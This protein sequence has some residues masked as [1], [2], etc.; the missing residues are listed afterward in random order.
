M[1]RIILPST[2]LWTR[3]RTLGWGVIWN[4]KNNS[5][6]SH[7]Q[8]I[9]Q[10]KKLRPYGHLWRLPAAGPAADKACNN[11]ASIMKK[12]SADLIIPKRWLSKF[13]YHDLKLFLQEMIINRKLVITLWDMW[14]PVWWCGE[15][16]GQDPMRPRL[17]STLSPRSFQW[18]WT[19][20]SVLAQHTLQSDY[21]T[22]PKRWHIVARGF[23]L[24]SSQE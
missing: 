10:Q 24:L 5:W 8:K 14:K 23:F 21:F 20:H 18:L 12:L 9:C 2:M 17:K 22:F 3:P 1:T 7:A 11:L 13:D 16:V 19:I 4:L 15:S 6:T